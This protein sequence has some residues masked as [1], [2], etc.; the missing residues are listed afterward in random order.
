MAIITEEPK[1]PKPSSSTQ[2]TPKPQPK[3]KATTSQSQPKSATNASPF[4]FWFY[5]TLIVSLITLFC[6]LLPSFSPQDP[7]TWF[8]NLP[9]NLRQHYAKGRVLKVQIT[10]NLPQVE[11]FSIQ[12]GPTKS[13]NQILIVHGFGC[14]SFAFQGVVKSLGLKGVRAIA[15]DLP[16]S[17]FSDKSMVVVEENAGTGGILG[18]FWDIYYEIK[19]KGIFWGF[20]QLIEKGYVNYEENENQVGV[21][22]REVVKAI[23]LGPEEMGRVLGQVIDAMGLAPVDLVLHDSALGLSANWI[24]ENPGLIRSIVVLDSA[25]TKTALPLWALDIP[26]VRETILGIG[27]VFERVLGTYCLNPVGKLEAEA[28]RILLKG[29]DGRKAIVGM[30][31]RLNYS[32]DLVEWGAMDVVKGLPLQVIW[33]GDSSKEWSA[34]G[35]SVAEAFPRATFVT[36][37]GGQWP[38]VSLFSLAFDVFD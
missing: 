25:P 32:F 15:I 9:G 17:G 38:Q 24:Y 2:K 37:S 28:H 19:E 11:V 36:H 30:G 31:K 34:E 20:D 29:R 16:G 14:S 27:F 26:V 6:V 1:E 33:S 12:E 3:S 23:E 35:R 7:K 18:R 22:K 10:P 5:F 21:S 4:H 8:L 13:D